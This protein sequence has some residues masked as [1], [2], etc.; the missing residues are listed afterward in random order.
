MM[1]KIMLG[2][3]VTYKR[4]YIANLFVIVENHAIYLRLITLTNS[5]IE[6]ILILRV[7]FRAK[8]LTNILRNHKT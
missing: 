8:F 1:K 4:E 7:F 5:S 6:I 2:Q 3:T